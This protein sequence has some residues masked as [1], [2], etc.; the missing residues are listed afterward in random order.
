MVIVDGCQVDIHSIVCKLYSCQLWCLI[1]DFL[2]LANL[3]PLQTT[4][5][6]SRNRPCIIYVGT[7]T[8]NKEAVSQG[9]LNSALIGRYKAF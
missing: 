5:S 9:L 3:R 8:T 7:L 4:L 1:H 2:N 6:S